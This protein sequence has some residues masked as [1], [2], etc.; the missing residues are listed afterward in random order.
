MTDRN[1]NTVLRIVH[2][3]ISTVDRFSL[4]DINPHDNEM[5]RLEIRLSITKWNTCSLI[6]C[7]NANA[8]RLSTMHNNC[9]SH[10]RFLR[11]VYWSYFRCIIHAFPI[12]ILFTPSHS[13]WFL[14]PSIIGICTPVYNTNESSSGQIITFCV[15]ICQQM[16][17]AS[18]S[19]FKEH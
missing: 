7:D 12:R 11:G 6:L 10:N 19:P 4:C 1:C 16:V 15:L 3:K 8:L 18:N 9:I 5:Q 2:R 14:W 17:T 13:L